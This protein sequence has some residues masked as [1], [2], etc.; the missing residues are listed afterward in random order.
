MK[1]NFSFPLCVVLVCALLSVGF[2]RPTCA[3]TWNLKFFHIAPANSKTA[4]VLDSY[5]ST[6]EDVTQGRV[7]ITMY[8]GATL[9][10]PSEAYELVTTGTADISWGFVG[11]FP[12]QFL[13]TEIPTLP[14]LGAS[15]GVIASRVL[16]ALREKFSEAFDKEYR[17]VHLLTIHSGGVTDTSTVSKPIRTMEDFQG[18]NLRTP[19][20]PITEMMKAFGANPMTISTRDLYSALEKGV[21]EGVNLGIMAVR[22]FKLH[23][24]CKYFHQTQLYPTAFWVVINKNVWDSMPEEIQEQIMGVSGVKGG[25]M[26]GSGWDKLGEEATKYLRNLPGKE[27]IDYSAKERARWTELARP[28]WDSHIKKV[29]AR[30]LPGREALDY[31]LKLYKEY[32]K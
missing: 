18:M 3:K 10:K 13:M 7:T 31:T 15:T 28:I 30:G 24:I 17:E 12:G 4:A 20:G 29:E 11:F 2:A 1:K 9:G 8:P 22:D 14:L 27:I 5:A 26:L 6:I 19:S 21:V 32:T 25:V 16:W 23:E